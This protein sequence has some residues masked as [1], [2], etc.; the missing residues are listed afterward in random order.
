MTR[1]TKIVCTL[2]PASNTPERIASLIAAGMNV[3]RVNF[4][5]GTLEQ[6]A[7]TIRIVRE[8]AELADTPIAILGDLQGPKI[9]V[10]RL[11]EPVELKAGDPITFAPEGQERPGELPTTY[12]EL[13]DDVAEGDVVLL[14]DGLMELIV[15]DVSKPRVRMRVIHGGTL[16]SH[17]GINLP[18]VKM[19]VPSLTEKDVR[20]LEFALE[21]ELDYIALSFV[22]EPKD[23]TDLRGRIPEGGP[24]VVVKVEKGMALDNLPSILEVSAA[25][26]VARGDLGVELPFEKVPLAQKRMIQLCNLASR[27]VI[28]ATQ[29]LESM[30]ENPRPTRAEASDVANAIIDGTD[31]VM[32]SAET[33]SGKFPVEAVK[34]MVRIAEEIE[35]SHILDAGPHYDL[36]LEPA[37]EG[38][39]S[40]EWAI[41][42]ATVEAVRRT[43]SPLIITFTHTGLTARVVSSFRP[44]VPIL[45]LTDS[46]RTYNQLALVWGVIPVLAPV[47]DTLYETMVRARSIAVERGL[48]ER[49]Q[50]CVITAG[51]PMHTAGTTNTLQVE[52]I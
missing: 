38:Y 10:G 35:R 39:T 24:P 49:G 25:A 8:Q 4:S 33:A 42:A 36:P 51:L 50:R 14:A 19:S 45:A 52:V 16:T 41:A 34:S 44:P 17:K 30:I 15:E 9:R 28:T 46:R 1:R 11:A 18:G 31:A 7:E 13:A 43:R 48:A 40:T 21:Q 20:D 37:E 5:H 29:V 23:V 32:L 12:R 6:H 27:P 22:R 3:A 2:G 47:S 26:M